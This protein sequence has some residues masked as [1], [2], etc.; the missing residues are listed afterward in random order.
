MFFQPGMNTVD[1][2]ADLRFFQWLGAYLVEDQ[3]FGAGVVEL[4]EK[5]WRSV[6]GLVLFEMKLFAIMQSLHG[7]LAL[8]HEK[9]MIGARMAV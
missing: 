7:T 3:P 8:D 5:S 2:F 4:V 9:G 1:H 6:D